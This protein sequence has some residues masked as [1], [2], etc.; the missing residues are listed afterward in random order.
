MNNRTKEDLWNSHTYAIFK[1]KVLRLEAK[2][3]NRKDLLTRL[4]T[5]VTHIHMTKDL[6][7]NVCGKHISNELLIR[8]KGVVTSFNPLKPLKE[9]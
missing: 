6:G 8:L 5:I 1:K 3:R 9:V 4:E 7:Y 2:F